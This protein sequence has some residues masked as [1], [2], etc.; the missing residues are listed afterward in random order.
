MALT[1]FH[2]ASFKTIQRAFASGNVALMECK[3]RATGKRVGVICAVFPLGQGDSVFIPLVQLFDGNPYDV[4][5]EVIVE[6]KGG[7]Q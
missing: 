5:E 3:L 6:E 7:A 1:H 2:Q 4:L